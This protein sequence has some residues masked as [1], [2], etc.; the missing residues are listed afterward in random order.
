M[1]GAA[2]GSMGGHGA[3]VSGAPSKKVK[4][5][6]SPKGHPKGCSCGKCSK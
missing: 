4:D 6:I 1:A 5:V 3:V 2:S